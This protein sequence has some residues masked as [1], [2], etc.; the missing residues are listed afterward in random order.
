M[1]RVVTGFIGR[2]IDREFRSASKV[3]WESAR[4]A[5][6]APFVVSTALMLLHRL[7]A[8]H[9]TAVTLATIAADGAKNA[10]EAFFDGVKGV[11]GKVAAVWGGSAEEDDDSSE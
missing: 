9:W 6:Y 7:D 10:A 1:I 2:V 3:V 11:V 8:E 4:A 5:T